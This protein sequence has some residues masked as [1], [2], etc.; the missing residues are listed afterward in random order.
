[1]DL[2]QVR[3]QHGVAVVVTGIASEVGQGIVDAVE[4]NRHLVQ[5]DHVDR[6]QLRKDLLPDEGKF[7]LGQVA[8]PCHDRHIQVRHPGVHEA[9]QGYAELCFDRQRQV[10]DGPSIAIDHHGEDHAHAA[11]AADGAHPGLEKLARLEDAH[12]EG[13]I[14]SDR[15]PLRG[16]PI[17]V[18]QFERD[19]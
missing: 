5:I 4:M 13:R 10:E 11:I 16:L 12:F 7:A 3:K 19:L 14:G 15:R 1:M 2:R 8:M 6:R 18:E 9:Q 17:T